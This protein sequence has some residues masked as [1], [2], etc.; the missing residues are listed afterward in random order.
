MPLP[1]GIRGIKYLPLALC[2]C[3]SVHPSLDSTEL[4]ILVIFEWEGL[5]TSFGLNMTFVPLHIQFFYP[6][7]RNV[8][9]NVVIIIR[10]QLA[11]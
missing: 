9:F 6:L 1:R 10:Y 4:S 2:V 5:V 3:A 8:I 11:Q 7:N